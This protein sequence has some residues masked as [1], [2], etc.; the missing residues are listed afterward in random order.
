[1]Q[2]ACF[3]LNHTW[4]ANHM[5]S[6]FSL[7]QLYTYNVINYSQPISTTATE[8]FQ[9]L[10]VCIPWFLETQNE[11]FNIRTKT[12]HKSSDDV[13]TL[14]RSIDMLWII[15]FII[16]TSISLWI[17]V[18]SMWHMMRS[19]LCFIRHTYTYTN[20][21]KNNTTAP[22]SVPVAVP[23]TVPVTVPAPPTPARTLSSRPKIN[24]V[25]LRVQQHKH[26]ADKPHEGTFE[27]NCLSCLCQTC[28]T[29]RRHNLHDSHRV[30]SDE[31]MQ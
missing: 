30:F 10:R 24:T 19:V 13:M 29:L 6:N 8:V 18:Y 22:A 27:H 31:P 4:M 3:V 9:L 20:R 26:S 14:S 21:F 17:G 25:Y 23:V 12:T 11:L 5:C 2:K 15:G 7:S 1:M 28:T 16:L